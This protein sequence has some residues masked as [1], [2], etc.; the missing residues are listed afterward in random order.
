MRKIS[1]LPARKVLFTS[2]LEI[3]ILGRSNHWPGTQGPTIC[4]STIRNAGGEGQSPLEMRK[5]VIL[6]NLAHL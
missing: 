5:G 4:S 3:F 2:V 1:R 6:I